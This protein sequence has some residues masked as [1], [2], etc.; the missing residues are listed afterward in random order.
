ML[1]GL[2]GAVWVGSVGGRWFSMPEFTQ[3][4]K[5]SEV[6]RLVLLA[7]GCCWF[8]LAGAVA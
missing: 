2:C 5:E 6:I 7:T 3:K 8:Q 4:E 1:C